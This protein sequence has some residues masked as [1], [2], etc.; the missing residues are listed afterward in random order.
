MDL[1]VVLADPLDTAVHLLLLVLMY[2]IPYTHSFKKNIS[3]FER[4]SDREIELL[5]SGLLPQ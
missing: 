1:D 4:Q 5:F 3:L 2:P